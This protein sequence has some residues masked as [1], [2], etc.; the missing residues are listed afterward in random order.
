[1][2]QRVRLVFPVLECD[3]LRIVAEQLMHKLAGAIKP[4]LAYT[5]IARA[6]P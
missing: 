6:P 5:P 2:M 4:L 3:T 1:M